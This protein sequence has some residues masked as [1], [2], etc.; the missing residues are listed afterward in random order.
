MTGT[1]LTGSIQST[2]YVSSDALDSDIS[3]KLLDVY[4]D[5]RA[6]NLD[7]TIQRLDTE[8]DTKKKS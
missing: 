2:L 7:E 4:P 1:E 5:G 8:M 3:I 6:Y